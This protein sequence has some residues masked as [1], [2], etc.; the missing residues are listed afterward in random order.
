MKIW[1]KSIFIILIV[2][3]LSVLFVECSFKNNQ[4]NKNNAVFN[5]YREIP[6]V[7][8]YEIEAIEAYRQAVSRGDIEYFE[9]GM[10]LSI[11]AFIGEDGK[12]K[13]FSAMFCEWLTELFG[14]TF[15]PV[16]YKWQDL[17]AGLDSGEISF[18]GELTRTEER[19]K[20]FY[21]TGALVSRPVKYFHIKGGKHPA[22]ITQERLRCGFISG[23]ATINS[24]IA[25]LV[26]GSYEV[27]LLDDFSY[28]YDALVSGKIDV[29]Y[30]SGTAEVNFL[31]HSDIISNNFYPLIRMPVS[32]ATKNKALKPFITVIDKALENNAT[33][34]LSEMYNQN[35]FYYTKYKLFSQFTEEELNYIESN[36]VILFS[37]EHDNYPASFYDTRINKW[38]GI[39]FDILK[40]IETLTGLK[41]T[42][43]H[44]ETASYSKLIQMLD[45]G[46]SSFQLEMI[47]A[48]DQEGKYLWSELTLNTDNPALISKTDV[49]SINIHEI[50]SVKVGLTK[51]LAYTNMFHKWFP[52]HNLIIEY[53]NHYE[54]FNA[55]TRGEVDMVMNSYSGLLYLTHYLERPGYKINYMFDYPYDCT[56][57]FNK[58]QEVLCSIINKSLGLID[59][60]G[61]TNQ[62]L[63]KTY[64]YR[65]KLAEAQVPW[66][67]GVSV[68]FFGVLALVA[69]MF[70]R[71]RLTSRELEKLVKK[72]THELALQTATL[73]TLFDSIPDLIFTKD[74]DLKFIHCN[75]SLLEHFGIKKEDLI[76][77]R[78]T[79]KLWMSFEKTEDDEFL[80]RKVINEEQQYVVEEYIPHIDGS[81]PLFETIKM[82]LILN[83]VGI[84]VLG[85]ARNITRRKEMEK[86]VLS[87]YEYS[88][89]L[90][91]ALAEITKSPTISAGILRDAASVVAQIGCKALKTNRVGIWNYSE[92]ENCLESILFYDVFSGEYSS[93]Q[94]YDL[95][96]RQEYEKLLKSERVIVM[97]DIDE[98]MLIS[99]VDSEYDHLCAALDAPIRVDG[100]LVGVVCVEQ[101]RSGEYAE[102]R[103]WRLEEQSFA[104]SLADL[105]ALAVSGSERRNARDSAETA[106]RTKSSFLANMS[107]EIR[108]PMNAILG[109][110]EILIQ[111]E[112][113]PRE[114]EEGLIRI[115]SSCE[116][117]LGIIN[118]IL[119]FSK[120]EAGKMDIMPA[121]YKVAGMIN[122][123][124]HLNMMRIES[125]PISFELN[126]DEKIPSWL[127]GDELRIKQILN[128]LLSNAFKYTDSGKVTL[129]V[130]HE[131]ISLINYLPDHYI[132]G[133]VK[134]LDPEKEGITLVLKVKDTGHGMTNDQL[135]KIFDDYS[136][137]NYERN[138]AVEGT[139]LGLAITQRLVN[140]MGGVLQVES[141]LDV[142]SVFTVKLPQETVDDEVL[143][144]EAA[145]NLINFRTSYIS[146]KKRGQLVRDIMPYGK[147]LI[148]DDVETNLFVAVGLMK[149]YK[150]QIE[151]AMSGK[152][153]IEKIKSGKEYDIIFMDHM[154]PEMDGIEA[155]KH[156]R[157]LGYKASIVALTANAVAGQAEVFKSN[158]FDDFISKPI[159]IRQ[160]N[161][162]LN[163][164]V[165]DKQPPEVIEAARNQ[166]EDKESGASSSLQVD[167]LLIESFIRDASKTISLLDEL[168]AGPE[169]HTSEELLKKFTI[170]VHGIKSSLWN[171]GEIE[172]SKFA[173]NLETAGREHNTEQI[174]SDIPDFMRQLRALLERIKNIQ[175]ERIN[176]I[177]AEEEDA[178]SMRDKLF[179]IKERTEDYDRKGVLEI[180][181]GIV[182]CNKEARD[183]LDKIK[184]FIIHSDFEEADKVIEAIMNSNYK[185]LFKDKTVE[186]LDITKGLARYSFD[187]KMYLK[188]LR[189]YAASVRAM[190]GAVEKTGEEQRM[191]GGRRLSDGQLNDYRI[192]VHGIKGTSLDIFADGIGTAAKDLEEAA[193]TEDYSFIEKNNPSFMEKAW[194]MVSDIED[195]ISRIEAENPKSQKDKPDKSVLANLL[196]ACKTYYMDGMDTAMAE[197][198]KYQYETDNDLVIWLRE[199]IDKMNIK[200]IVEKL[201]NLE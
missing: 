11:E 133:Q 49:R 197:L 196:D 181:S 54:T 143:G 62:W 61:I 136:R 159:D 145:D 162:V 87:D 116:L 3:L 64:D 91:D 98:C 84:G 75:K 170:I 71:S 60:Q 15:K 130:S 67:I 47:R 201:S 101:W 184:E 86:K 142:G 122:D 141:K 152:E 70:I 90:S 178:E 25:E 58:K 6:G 63:T 120:I 161:A 153:A 191:S 169:W 95:H 5:S 134:W 97:N 34:Y 107:H 108:T 185:T 165:R 127:I 123:S 78:E 96:S 92:N 100:K 93:Q 102:E 41:F 80:D 33:R 37:A 194:K 179:E 99:M 183:V 177:S 28:V 51:G 38:T 36:P 74:K 10:P 126:V 89:E 168:I 156:I 128:N 154:M 115:Y 195:M 83:G 139:G 56:F 45:D 175:N 119:D 82:P 140:L 88:K 40:E 24:V 17:F 8:N 73:T 150:L 132:N 117:L 16:I 193:K 149:L 189:S 50:Y 27:I 48:A 21:M 65:V 72:R 147:I 187:E 4:L 148:V 9:Y 106:S 46:E 110:T 19:L 52:N 155:V 35:Y 57:G 200:Q 66:S 182:N 13:G 43:A 76:G 164:L 112:T 22:E 31:E 163:K 55:L 59:T 118:D 176:S 14:I 172:L 94:N 124:V 81:S 166:K 131:T 192:K 53:E 138:S 29:F 157:D 190:L 12:I 39:G 1:K 104:S 103:R 23:A 105:M 20:N 85:I 2:I 114:I 111:H 167:S 171:I 135:E 68:L 18:T 125:K 160:L 173:L 129:S 198:E 42:I 32:L 144:K 121:K 199:N 151:T 30:C 44:D 158:G 188:V 174:I 77:K 69:V 79:N 137:F 186:G 113:L 26:P 7:T 109:V 146:K 180:I